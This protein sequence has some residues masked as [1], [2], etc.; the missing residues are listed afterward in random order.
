MLDRLEDVS[1]VV[2]VLLVVAV[3]VLFLCPQNS[4]TGNQTSK[5][6][7][8]LNDLDSDLGSCLAV[9]CKLDQREGPTPQLLLGKAK[10]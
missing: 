8:D 1:F 6:N 5:Q 7:T 2:H 4:K 10:K 9:H 3:D